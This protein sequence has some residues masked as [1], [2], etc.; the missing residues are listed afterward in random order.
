MGHD[1]M[2]YEASCQFIVYMS[3]YSLNKNF[4]IFL[5]V[6]HTMDHEVVP[7]P[8]KICDWLLNLSRDHFGLHQGKKC[9]SD[10]GVWDP[11]KTKFLRPTLSTYMVQRVLW[12]ERQKRCSSTTRRGPMANGVIVKFWWFFWELNTRELSNLII[13]F[14]SRNCAFCTYIKKIQHIHILMNGHSSWST[15]GLYPMRGPKAL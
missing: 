6:V 2:F 11:Q 9:Q 13:F 3:C 15:I 7:R 1:C 10:H 5:G 12:W 4:L 14:S 8:C